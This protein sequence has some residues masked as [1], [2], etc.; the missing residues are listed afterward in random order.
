MGLVRWTVKT[1]AR[2][3]E[4]FGWR[5]LLDEGDRFASM[6]EHFPVKC[7]ECGCEAS[8]LKAWQAARGVPYRTAEQ[9][10]RRRGSARER[11]DK[12]TGGN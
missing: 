7:P 5:F 1:A 8:G 11:G 9:L 2:F 6:L 4:W 3:W 12:A 10:R